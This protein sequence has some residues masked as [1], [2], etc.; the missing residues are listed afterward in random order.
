MAALCRIEKADLDFWV[1]ESHKR[2]KE[3]REE[4]ILEDIISPI[5]NSTYD[6]GIR[7]KMSQRLLDRMPSLGKENCTN[8]ANYVLLMMELHLL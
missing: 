3:A 8:A 5:N 2:A 7:D 1:K 6:E 4:K